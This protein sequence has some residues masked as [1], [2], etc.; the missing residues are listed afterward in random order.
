MLNMELINKWLEYKTI[1]Q[2]RSS[3][4]A[5]KYRPYLE[6]LLV[7]CKENNLQLLEVSTDDL[8]IFTGVYLFKQ[9]DIGPRT[10]RTV[11]A[12]VRGFYSW[13]LKKGLIHTDPA[14]GVPYPKAPNKIP[15]AFPL[16]C[17][18]RLIWAPD[19]TEFM[20]VRDAVIL[21]LLMGCGL[22]VSGLVR[23]NESDLL[24]SSDAGREQ[25]S[26]RTHE[27]GDK[28]RLVPAPD[29]VRLLVRAYLGHDYLSKVNRDL[30]AGDRV[31]FISTRNRHRMS[32]D[33][34]GEALRLGRKSVNK[35]IVKYGEKLNIPR[36]YLHPHA[37]RHLYGAELTEDDVDVLDRMA[38]MGQSDV[39]SAEIYS[40]I[41][42]RKLRRIVTRSNPLTKMHTP[43]SD[44]SKKLEQ[45]KT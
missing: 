21:S 38:L 8:D 13:C 23:L 36:E 15:V 26:I 39:K 22:R 18:E 19:L 28:E 32:C 45:V 4:T 29:E 11:V 30:E 40:H 42:Q 2:G 10:R 9:M 34:Y 41:A 24:W 7:F 20:G 43:V 14:A 6:K 1:N 37:L 17:A 27:K 5:A 33:L 35:I 12:A 44:L 3:S 31:L 16:D 25:L